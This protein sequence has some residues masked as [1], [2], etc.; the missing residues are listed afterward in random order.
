MPE[1]A[2]FARREPSIDAARASMARERSVRA[3][4][5]YGMCAH[6]LQDWAE[7]GLCEPRRPGEIDVEVEE[8][9]EEDA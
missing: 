3:W 5:A 1:R 7:D 9:R 8:I 2:F 6:T 4:G